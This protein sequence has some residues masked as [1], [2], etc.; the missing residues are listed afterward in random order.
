MVGECDFGNI[1]IQS[2]IEHSLLRD[3]SGIAIG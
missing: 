1:A 3:R 2:T